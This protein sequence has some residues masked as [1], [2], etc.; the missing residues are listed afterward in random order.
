[1]LMA[2][3]A[4]PSSPPKGR[5]P[6]RPCPGDFDA[7]FV[8]KGR[9]DCEAHYRARRDTITRWLVECGKDRLIKARADHVARLRAA[10]EWMTRQTRLIEHREIAAPRPL[11]R[12]LD[13]RR[14]SITLARHAAQHLRVIR[15]GGFIV[16][17]ASD[18]NWWVGSKRMS[19]AQMLDLAVRKGFEPHLHRDLR[20]G[21]NR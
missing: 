5:A 1:M 10:G 8:E 9:L 12:V 19:A 2:A 20:D 13:R 16:S 15:N 6:L 14:V 4:G 17:P 7:V 11:Q 3:I 21:V 18:G